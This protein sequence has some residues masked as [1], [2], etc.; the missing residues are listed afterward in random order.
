MSPSYHF[1]HLSLSTVAGQCTDTTYQPP[2]TTTSSYT[3]HD[4]FRSDFRFR[5]NPQHSGWKKT[6]HQTRARA[7]A[8]TSSRKPPPTTGT[9]GLSMG[10]MSIFANAS[11]ISIKECSIHVTGGNQYNHNTFNHNTYSY[12]SSSPR[13]VGPPGNVS[14]PTS[15][16]SNTNSNG[17]NPYGRNF[18]GSPEMFGLRTNG[19]G[20]DEP[21]SRPSAQKLRQNANSL[22]KRDRDF[23][24]SF[25]DVSAQDYFDSSEVS[26]AHWQPGRTGRSTYSYSYKEGS[27]DPSRMHAGPGHRG[28]LAYKGVTSDDLR[29]IQVLEDEGEDEDEDEDEDKTS[30]GSSTSEISITAFSRAGSRDDTSA[31]AT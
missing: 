26:R 9:S 15:H 11:N 16:T 7:N 24:W 31:R 27:G 25:E 14:Q 8:S 20:I 21:R 6:F 5:D 12:H 3:H 19:S 29:H 28:S 17:H 1:T 13:T 18:A 10:N 30:T 23:D 2:P 4:E 22:V